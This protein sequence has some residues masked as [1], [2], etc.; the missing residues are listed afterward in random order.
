MSKVVVGGRRRRMKYVEV[1]EGCG[2]EGCGGD[3]MAKRGM[4][5]R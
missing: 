5:N 4:L 3:V 1:E 2:V